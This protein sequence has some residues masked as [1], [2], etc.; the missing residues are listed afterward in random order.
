MSKSKYPD[1]TTTY[2]YSSLTNTALSISSHSFLPCPFSGTIK[3]ITL[4]N[5]D[6][7]GLSTSGTIRVYSISQLD[8]YQVGSNWNLIMSDTYNLTGFDSDRVTV[9][10]SFS[11]NDVLVF[12]L[13]STSGGY[14]VN[15]NIVLEYNI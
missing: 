9:S 1:Y 8:N 6:S 2:G 13:I 4:K 7:G 12:V 5:L 3:R 15:A 10:G 11:E 14:I